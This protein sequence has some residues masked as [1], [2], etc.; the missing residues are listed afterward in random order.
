MRHALSPP[1]ILVHGAGN[2][3]G[4]WRFW[5]QELADHGWESEAIDLRGHGA[6]AP[7]DLSSTSMGDYADDVRRAVARCAEPPVL[8]GWSMGGLLALMVAATGDVAACVALAPSAP[9]R[10]VDE[11]LPLRHGEFGPDEYGITS[12]DPRDQPAMPDL[13]L[14]ERAIALATLGRDSRLARDERQRG[15]VVAASPSPLLLVTGAL[16]TQ[17]SAARYADLPLPADHLAVAD[18]SHWGLVLNRRALATLVPA[19]VRWLAA[20][21]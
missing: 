17:W 4:V 7:L 20:Q 15:I 6:S 21:R 12:L 3:A 13:D 18:A 9:A 8:I 14:E 5:Q 16:D 2:S 10:E 1:V 19:V 11:T